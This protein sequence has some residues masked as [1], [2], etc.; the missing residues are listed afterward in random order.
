ML[1]PPGTYNS[2]TMI[3]GDMDVA[4]VPPTGSHQPIEVIGQA[5]EG[6]TETGAL[7]TGPA[8]SSAPGGPA[9]AAAIASEVAPGLV[10][11]DSTLKLRRRRGRGNRHGA[12]L[13]R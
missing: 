11:I 13:H 5:S 10:D 7:A 12:H 6:L 2:I 9:N 8:S 4:V 1:L 3:A